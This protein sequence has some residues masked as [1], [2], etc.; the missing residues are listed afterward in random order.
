ML[1]F[2]RGKEVDGWEHGEEATLPIPVYGGDGRHRPEQH[3]HRPVGVNLHDG[4]VRGDAAVFVL[5]AGRGRVGGKVAAM[6]APGHLRLDAGGEHAAAARVRAV[7]Q[8][9]NRLSPAHR[10][11][12]HPVH[13][14]GLPVWHFPVGIR[15]GR[16]FLSAPVCHDVLARFH[17][18]LCLS[19]L[20][21][22]LCGRGNLL[23]FICVRHDDRGAGDG[24][25]PCQHL[26]LLRAC[27]HPDPRQHRPLP[28]KGAHDAAGAEKPHDEPRA[29]QAFLL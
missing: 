29:A 24:L 5:S 8:E 13:A 12:G 4:G 2:R 10:V 7:R 15:G 9:K 6:G 3:V 25:L 22:L 11:V 1:E 21:V 20:D 16:R 19:G 17:A 27:H 26:E 23:L 14:G 28:R 18:V